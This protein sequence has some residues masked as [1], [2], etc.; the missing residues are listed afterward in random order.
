MC[1]H[2]LPDV[3][4]VTNRALQVRCAS[5]TSVRELDRTAPVEFTGG[6]IADSTVRVRRSIWA[7]GEGLD[8]PLHYVVEVTEEH[9]GLDDRSA[10]GELT[11]NQE[12]RL[13]A[14]RARTR[15]TRS[16]RL[17]CKDTVASDGKGCYLLKTTTIRKILNELT[18]KGLADGVVDDGE[19]TSKRWW[20]T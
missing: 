12:R 18:D 1:A 8:T 10:R 7:D 5:T 9:D 19:G 11:H 20:P 15:E 6:E 2:R 3:P 13:A 4:R 14:I 16:R 17:R